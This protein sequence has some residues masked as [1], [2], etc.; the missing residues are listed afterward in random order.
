MFRAQGW[1]TAACLVASLLLV[2]GCWNR[3]HRIQAPSALAFVDLNPILLQGITVNIPASY[4][5]DLTQ[6]F[7]ISPALPA[8][9]TLDP[10]TGT[11]SGTPTNLTP[12]AT[13][14]VTA[15]NAGGETETILTITIN[16][17]AP[18]DLAY[19]EEDIKY[20]GQISN[21]L[22]APTFGCGP[23]DDWD[24][25]P[26]LPVGLTLDPVTGVISGVPT[27]VIP[28]TEFVVFASNITGVDTRSIFI[29]VE[30]PAPCDLSYG[31]TDFVFPPTVELIP[32]TPTSAC[33][34]VDLFEITPA[35][36]A[37]LALD[38]A[39]GTISGT[40]TVETDEETFVVT[41]SNIYG[42][43][44]VTITIRIAPVFEYTAE[45]MVADYDP[46]TGLGMFQTRLFLEEG[47]RNATFPTPI[48]G[49]SLA[50]EHDGAALTPVAV[51]PGAD[52]M[53]LGMGAG[54]DF[55]EPLITENAVTVGIVFD[56]DLIELLLADAIR[57]VVR[58]DYET[59]PAQFLGNM[60]G[61]DL[62]LR[63]GNPTLSA[64]ENEVA[65][66]GT[67]SVLPV[68]LDGNVT[69][70]PQEITADE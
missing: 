8:G 10:T 1:A 31:E 69:L 23:V 35:L 59:E 36:P 34:A 48:I 42:S 33:G 6:D 39:T 47:D 11:I 64:V 16:P 18:C 24:I 46:T 58:V 4:L 61:M 57:E 12:E 9:L 45:D 32:N 67:Y 14:V 44:T 17:Q 68:L 40:P 56:L 63:W 19:A 70:S 62:P 20:I 15:R 30:T 5:G 55:F 49:L 26:T 50:L 22:N 60:D 41:A 21:V 54:P 37:G 65:L 25:Q 28:R 13:Y 27:E 3:S 66:S 43:T 38:P 2:S 53:G 52:L 7:S 29:E 51:T